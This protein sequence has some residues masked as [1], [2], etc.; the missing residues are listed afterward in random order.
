MGCWFPCSALSSTLKLLPN[1]RIRKRYDQ[2]NSIKIRSLLWCFVFLLNCLLLKIGCISEKPPNIACTIFQ[3][4]R[5]ISTIMLKSRRLKRKL[6]IDN[7]KLH[8][9]LKRL[10]S[11]R[12][13]IEWKYNKIQLRGIRYFATTLPQNLFRLK[14]WIWSPDYFQISKSICRLLYGQSLN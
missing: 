9:K 14:T 11:F 8:Y 7:Y 2:A 13:S 6:R 1:F 3:F 4:K 10:N 5:W 12:D